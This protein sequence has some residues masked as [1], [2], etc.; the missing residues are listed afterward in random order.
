MSELVAGDRVRSR[1]CRGAPLVREAGIRRRVGK[2]R[3]AVQAVAYA[4]LNR[5]P[6][7]QAWRARNVRTTVTVFGVGG[8]SVRGTGMRRSAL[9]SRIIAGGLRDCAHR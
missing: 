9:A 8:G 4:Q 1:I 2:R 3:A 6:S 7:G 5:R